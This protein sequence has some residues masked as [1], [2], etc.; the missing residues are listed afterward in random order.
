MHVRRGYLGWGIFLILTG[1]VPLALRSGY[2]TDEQIARVWTLWP[3][4]LIGIGVGLLLSRTRF[5]FIGGLIVAATLG[6]MAGGFLSSGVGD[7]TSG[8][9][10]QGGGTVPFPTREGTFATTGARVD[11]QVECGNVNVGVQVG[12]GWRVEGEDAKGTGPRVDATEQTLRARP[13]DDNGT[14]FWALG[15]RDTWQV[16]LPDAVPLNL[17]LQLNAGQARLALAG[18]MLDAFNLEL[19]AGSAA[20]D[21]TSVAEIGGFDVGMNAGSLGVTL[22]NISM[23]GS[24]AANAGA[25]RLC[26][27]AGVALRLRTGESIVASYDYAGHGLVQDGSTWATPGFDT[28]SVK[29]DLETT[30][31][32]GSF[33]LDP[34]A[35]CD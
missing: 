9:C 10:G 32:A 5:D 15:R 20:V 19:N 4:I 21:L 25:I 23:S 34:E 18:A 6:L 22:P 7:F 2:L 17:S 30:A 14:A 31:N 11:L 1:A 24:I 12:N 28:A 16:T 26:V 35:G 3:L 8:A 33:T 13:T 29:I 27:P